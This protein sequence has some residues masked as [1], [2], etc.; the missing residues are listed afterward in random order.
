MQQANEQ[1]TIQRSTIIDKAPK[2][3]GIVPKNLQAFVLI[4]LA[5]LMVVIMALTGHKPPA[6][7]AAQPPNPLPNL[8]P[9]NTEKV[10]EFE[11]HIEDTQR[12][13][14]PQAEAAL[15]REQKQLAEERSGPAQPY[16]SSPYGTPVTS[17]NP[18]GAY[19]P[20][21][22]ASALPQPGETQPTSTDA[23]KDE[24]RKRQ[25]ASLFSDNVA[26][27]YRKDATAAST[28]IHAPATSQNSTDSASPE[29]QLISQAAAELARQG[30]LLAQAQQQGLPKLTL[31][32][33]P[34][35]QNPSATSPTS[36]KSANPKPTTVNAPAAEPA[37][38]GRKQYVLFEGTILESVLINRL[39]GSFSGPVE[40]L[41]SED[42]YSHDR[43]HLLI[44]AGAKVLGEASK[45]DTFGLARLAVAF[46]RLIMPDG[47]SVSLDQFKGL[48]Q[49]GATALKDKVNNHYAEIF[50]ASLA[51][52]VLGGAAQLGT[53]NLLNESATDR[54]RQG[55]GVGVA[56]AGEQI[57]NRF[58]NI[59][60]TVT[61]REGTRVKIYLSSDLL[62]PDYHDHNLPPNL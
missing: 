54:I 33:S 62:L 12:S 35:A 23:L 17:P 10:S 2:P 45:V 51:L 24:Q 58:L 8:R 16:P 28:A 14:A 57:L 46:H 13:T 22:Y 25:Y 29:D 26:L 48:D 19:P 53:A 40:C 1:Q 18:A 20:N 43:Q 7:V 50:G 47:Y 5:L 32:S 21:G 4:G 49:Q 59:L 34:Q 3:A 30:H 11:K 27:T 42:I 41:V 61:I 6:P 15:L 55:F 38:D 39:D 56:D 9:L 37:P 31:P 36:E 44:P 52:G 60:P